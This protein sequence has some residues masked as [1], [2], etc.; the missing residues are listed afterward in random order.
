MTGATAAKPKGL[1]LAKWELLGMAA[2]HPRLAQGDVA[3]LFELC[4]R[5]NEDARAAWPSIDRMAKDTGKHRSTVIRSVKRL[6]AH[7]FVKTVK[8]GN[9]GGETNRYQPAFGGPKVVAST[10]LDLV[11]P[12]HKGGGVDASNLVAPTPP[13]PIYEPGYEAGVNRWGDGPSPA[14]AGSGAALQSKDRKHPEFWAAYPKASGVFVAEQTIDALL[15]QGVTLAEL[16]DGATRYAV[17]IKAK[18]QRDP[19]RFTKG[20][21]KWLQER[22]W[23][24]SY[25]LQQERPAK[26]AKGPQEGTKPLPAVTVLPEP[27]RFL[28][29]AEEA[30]VRNERAKARD[31]KAKQAATNKALRLEVGRLCQERPTL[32]PLFENVLTAK[33]LAAWLR[34]NPGNTDMRFTP[35]MWDELRSIVALHRADVPLAAVL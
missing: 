10:P 18:A 19:D 5:Y 16:V 3:V 12:T 28:S 21:A 31:L 32:R 25:E 11:A 29:V 22:C 15:I 14:L 27:K 2:R 35:S 8:H 20:A 30:A 4:D 26:P 7:G 33:T 34:Y 13:K 17:W 6:S 1:L 9:R 23:L 24:D